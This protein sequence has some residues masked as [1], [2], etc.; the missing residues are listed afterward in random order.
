MKKIVHIAFSLVLF[1]CASACLD[2]GPL[3]FNPDDS[4]TEY[5][6]DEHPDNWYFDEDKEYTIAEN[7]FN[8]F[9]L[10]SDHEGEKA[11]IHALYLGDLETIASDTVIV[12]CHGNSTHM[13]V[14]YPRAQLLYYTGGKSRYGVLMMDYRGFGLS[15]GIS[16]EASLVSDVEACIN[17]LKERGLSEDRMIL[18]GFSLG[19]I[20]SI[21]LASNPQSLGAHKLMLEA[22]VGSINTM[23]QN[24][25][26]L[27]MPASFFADLGTN[28]IEEIKN[29]KQDLLWIH[30]LD[31]GFLDY[32]THG[33]AIYNNHNA[34]Y[35]ISIPVRGGDHGDTP[36]KM[37]EVKYMQAMQEFIGR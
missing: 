28:N 10:E 22:P 7:E 20:P 17:W 14:Y 32:T 9:Q 34:D 36:F 1:C 30:G 23:S 3:L 4:I 24:G 33:E 19:S 5:L 6:W 18:Y 15:T 31:D 27:S 8:Y 16:S 21:Q 12:Y 2:L 29:V 35:K 11:E 13:D 26:S 25:S 37:G